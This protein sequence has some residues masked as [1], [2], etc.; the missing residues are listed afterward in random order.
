LHK[1]GLLSLVLLCIILFYTL[2]SLNSNSLHFAGIDTTSTVDDNNAGSVVG[3][4]TYKN[5]SFYRIGAWYVFDS[6]DPIDIFLTGSRILG[7]SY[8]PTLWYYN[9]SD[10]SL[11]ILLDNVYV[12]SLVAGNFSSS[13]LLELAC[14][15][16]G[17][18]ILNM[19]EFLSSGTTGII[20]NFSFAPTEYMYTVNIAGVCEDILL[21]YPHYTMY[22]LNMTDGT[23][24]SLALP[25]SD[26]Y[27]QAI[28]R[29]DC[30]QDSVEDIMII[31]GDQPPGPDVVITRLISQIIYGNNLSV[32]ILC[33]LSIN[34]TYV[35]IGNFD[36]D[37]FPEVVIFSNS[38]DTGILLFDI[39]NGE[40]LDRFSVV[41]VFLDEFVD[42]TKKFLIVSQDY[43]RYFILD[44][45]NSEIHPLEKGY[46]IAAVL[47][48]NATLIVFGSGTAIDLTSKSNYEILDSIGIEGGLIDIITTDLDSDGLDDI[49]Y[50]AQL[51]F[52][53]Y[54]ISRI[55]L[56]YMP[57]DI[58]SVDITPDYPTTL[59][60]IDITV[61]AAETKFRIYRV[62]VEISPLNASITLFARE[63]YG[64]IIEF[65]GSLGSLPAGGYE[66]YIYVLDIHGNVNMSE[67]I[68]INVIGYRY[69]DIEFPISEEFYVLYP[70]ITD[71]KEGA[72]AAIFN[73]S[74]SSSIIFVDEN[75]SIVGEYPIGSKRVL[76]IEDIDSDLKDEILLYDERWENNTHLI[77]FYY[78]DNDNL[79]TLITNIVY[80]EESSGVAR[81]YSFQRGVFVVANISKL[82]IIINVSKVISIEFG[83]NI[84]Y[85]DVYSYQVA[86]LL[87][88]S[89]VT[90][91][92]IPTGLLESYSPIESM[93]GALILNK[94]LILLFNNT[95]TLIFDRNVGSI[96]HTFKVDE[97]FVSE[98]YIVYGSRVVVTF[99]TNESQRYFG[100]FQTQKFFQ[101]VSIETYGSPYQ[102]SVADM[103]GDRKSEF[104]LYCSSGFVVLSVDD[105][106]IE[107]T[108]YTD[109]TG[110]YA[111]ITRYGYTFIEL[112]A[113]ALLVCIPYHSYWDVAF[114]VDVDIFR[115]LKIDVN[116][117][118]VWLQ[119]ETN[120]IR[121][122]LIDKNGHIVS[123]AEVFAKIGP[124]HIEFKLQQNNTFIAQ[125]TPKDLALGA[126]NLTIY[127]TSRYY[128][129]VSTLVRLVIVGNLR[130]IALMTDVY[131]DQLD[132]Q[133]ITVYVADE[134]Y[135]LVESSVSAYLDGKP[136]NS[137]SDF[138]QHIIEV[139]A[140]IP[141]G[142]H[143]LKLTATSIYAIKNASYK[144]NIYVFGEAKYRIFGNGI[145]VSAIQG[146][147]AIIVLNLTDGLGYPV[148]NATIR[149]SVGG[150][151]LLMTPRM[152][153]YGSYILP[154]PTDGL[155]A[156]V[157]RFEVSILH[158]YLRPKVMSGNFTIMGVPT[159]SIWLKENVF[160]Q[161]EYLELSAI[162]TDLYGYPLENISVVA[163]LGNRTFKMHRISE[164][165]F[166]ARI[167][168]NFRHGNYTL[169]I[170][171]SGLLCMEGSNSTT[172]TI[173]A[174]PPEIEIATSFIPLLVLF[175]AG[176][177][178]GGFV[179]YYK[180]LSA[181]FQ[182]ARSPIRVI[183]TLRTYYIL[184]F[185][186]F[187]ASLG[188]SLNVAK[189]NPNLSILIGS[190]A[191]LLI[192][193]M[194]M[195]WVLRDV[196]MIISLGARRR[197]SFLVAMIHIA[198][199]LGT[200]YILLWIGANLEWFQAYVLE[201]TTS[202]LGYNIPQL[203]LSIISAFIGSFILFVP[204]TYMRARNYRKHI[205]E[206]I[207]AGAQS[208]IVE[209]EIQRLGKELSS[210]I[211]N[212]TIAFIMIVGFS[213]ASYL[214]FITKYASLLLMIALPILILIV[215]IIVVP[216]ITNMLS[217]AKK[218]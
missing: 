44:P 145:N 33:N 131:I 10:D 134:Y 83:V 137:T 102:C 51:E 99:Y 38:S 162:V 185:L 74:F 58:V 113:D 95:L 181:A 138:P 168:L 1:A 107:K 151:S 178:A 161:Y 191:F 89:T 182:L 140:K 217:R 87:I 59:D 61:L 205:D 176:I 53:E 198:L 201:K 9:A 204:H 23:N 76:G 173:L 66:V 41:G 55:I 56:D 184:C 50:I 14:F 216:G 35:G 174:K 45:Y 156:G 218:T 97:Q 121:V 27:P 193:A 28:Y 158:T 199:V 166:A 212:K 105:L 106:R 30:N 118:H 169:T 136:I 142:K 108:M 180:Y 203:A 73:E 34:Y 2:Y 65:Q 3:M 186:G 60:P 210:S 213:A 11:S 6:D 78:L 196:Y 159:I 171:V 12:Y 109:F 22:I 163:I 70:Y 100:T 82:H 189:E 62:Y 139:Y 91:Y 90:I 188:Y 98:P 149:F 94:S 110:Y 190:C 92:D 52:E 200:L 192:I 187:V 24:V 148:G 39:Q 16:G 54:M 165:K 48:R 144:I 31:W 79:Y 194:S 154:M 40:I 68:S 104:V 80:G 21:I 209:K 211:R 120:T 164:I 72:V 81:Q 86:A 119:N 130:I 115:V 7:G 157:H 8:I 88:N 170:K 17:L 160:M 214:T 116:I 195:L 15:S 36:R 124:I 26:L 18:V 167:Y 153:A 19:S 5:T 112:K 75:L 96:L 125:I 206:I 215:A 128:R 177:M 13:P 29:F 133:N 117:S 152:E 207:G 77:D 127:A 25:S 175:S 42:D 143:I 57:P 123:D 47:R 129:P 141:I 4:G 146:E 172:I 85:V 69:K 202:I 49:I 103:D 93:S 135:H 132:S 122:I 20:Y 46:E 183:N 208:I 114:I 179:L 147:T 71:Y 63:T 126:Y 67:P 32:E 64:Q 84:C 155:K 111:Y 197:L 101:S 37:R 43:T 150:R